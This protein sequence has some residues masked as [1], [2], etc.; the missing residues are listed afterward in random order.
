MEKERFLKGHDVLIKCI[1]VSLGT[2]LLFLFAFN[3]ALIRQKPL[4]SHLQ[5]TLLA[6][7]TLWEKTG[8]FAEA[9]S[10]LDRADTS[11]LAL[12]EAAA[13]GSAPKLE[14][15]HKQLIWE[16]EP[17]TMAASPAFSRS[18]DWT[19]RKE[20]PDYALLFGS[21]SDHPP[22]LMS[23]VAERLM[24]T[25]GNRLPGEGGEAIELSPSLRARGT[26]RKE[27]PAIPVP[28]AGSSLPRSI[29]LSV[30]IDSA[31]AVRHVLILRSSGDPAMDAAALRTLSQ[32]K[33]M[34]SPQ[35]QDGSP[36]WGWVELSFLNSGPGRDAEPPAET[37]PRDKKE[38]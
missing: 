11:L 29:R 36:V 23:T 2:H 33:F 10:D 17:E 38:N 6:L 4:P 34:S 14:L 15:F 21:L 13:A 8:P 18:A 5:F 24:A 27:F 32:S 20:K 1:A 35:N 26:A 7:P 28:E 19:F 9:T 3:V 22:F 37:S 16:K 25:G 12:T 31:G 30:A